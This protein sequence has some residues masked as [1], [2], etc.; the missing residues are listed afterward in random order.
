MWHLVKQAGEVGTGIFLRAH[1]VSFT[2]LVSWASPTCEKKI[3]TPRKNSSTIPG[4]WMVFEHCGMILVQGGVVWATLSDQEDSGDLFG[5]WAAIRETPGAE[6]RLAG[7]IVG[8]WFWERNFLK[9]ENFCLFIVLQ[10]HARYWAPDA[11]G[12]PPVARNERS[13]QKTRTEK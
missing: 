4:S 11:W 6:H 7:Q 1:V 8:K 10:P 3:Q 9:S 2:N 13:T 5:S 12:E